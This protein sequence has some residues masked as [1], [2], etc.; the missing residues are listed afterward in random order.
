MT[1]SNLW[2]S[3]WTLAIRAKLQRGHDRVCLQKLQPRCGGAQLRSP[4]GAATTP[5]TARWQPLAA[6]LPQHLVQSCTL[7]KEPPASGRAV[8]CQNLA[9][10]AQ[11]SAP[12]WANLVGTPASPD[13]LRT[14]LQ[15]EAL[16]TW[17]SL[18][19]F[20]G[21][22]PASQSDGPPFPLPSPPFISHTYYPNQTY[23]TSNFI[24]TS[25]SQRAWLTRGGC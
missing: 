24:L 7:P 19:R 16:P 12:F 22:T 25:V 14:A 17:P 2:N 18:Y 8:R 3:N 21:A 6:R 5:S 15:V 9:V 20:I 10:S 1:K 4:C 23:C 13:F 11:G